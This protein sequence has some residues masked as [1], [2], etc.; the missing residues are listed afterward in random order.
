MEILLLFSVIH[1]FL[2]VV[3][4][5]VQLAHFRQQRAKGNNANVGKKTAKKKS[6]I[7]QSND[8]SAHVEGRSEH[9]HGQ[10]S[11]EELEV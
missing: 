7:V 2:P 10:G 9:T 8:Q 1:L 4:P 11:K 6:Q 5:V 3:R